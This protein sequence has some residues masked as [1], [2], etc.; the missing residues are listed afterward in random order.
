MF[1][2]CSQVSEVLSSVKRFQ[3]IVLVFWKSVFWNIETWNLI[4]IDQ[5]FRDAVF[6]TM[7]IEAISTT[8]TSFSI[9]QAI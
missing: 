3:L 1:F 6:L 8:E 2:I 7:M 5:K 4:D 9:Y